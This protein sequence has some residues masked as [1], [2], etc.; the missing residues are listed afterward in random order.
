V[1]K[2][3]PTSTRELA[4]RFRAV[5]ICAARLRAMALS[6]VFLL[7]AGS[8]LAA[9]QLEPRSFP[10]Q[11]VESYTFK[12]AMMGRAYDI[13]VGLP[14]DYAAQPN[15]KYPALLVTAP[16]QRDSSGAGAPRQ[17]PD[18]A[19]ERTGVVVRE[20]VS[21]SLTPFAT[22]RRDSHAPRARQAR[23]RLLHSRRR[24]A[25]RPSHKWKGRTPASHIT[26][27]S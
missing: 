7:T 1:A 27:R 17:C 13:S 5:E 21:R 24:A 11:R 20:T 8:S 10:Q 3:A 9:Q 2:V 16:V 15:K 22:R 23:A 12:S 14:R 4:M 18:D 6:G 19:R 26:I 25:E